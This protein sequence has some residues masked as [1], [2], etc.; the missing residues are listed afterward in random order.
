MAR[1]F[2]DQ[3]QQHVAEIAV[4]EDAAEP[5]AAVM[6]AKPSAS[7]AEDASCMPPFTAS[8]PMSKHGRIL[9]QFA[10]SSAICRRKIEGRQLA[11]G[12]DIS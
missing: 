10:I 4:I 3:L 5:P 9:L 12:L 6:A 1:L 7:E 11:D 8:M 2:G